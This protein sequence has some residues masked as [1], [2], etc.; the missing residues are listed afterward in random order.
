MIMVLD[1]PGASRGRRTIPLSSPYPSRMVL[2]I[3]PPPRGAAGDEWP[4]WL[5]TAAESARSTA[6]FASS[7]RH[8][9]SE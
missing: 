6:R 9:R 2:G 4:H 5:L 1:P 3:V 8:P 7:R